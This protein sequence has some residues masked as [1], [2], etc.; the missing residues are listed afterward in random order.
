MGLKR[1][2]IEHCGSVGGRDTTRRIVKSSSKHLRRAESK[3]I[4]RMAKQGGI[5]AETD[6]KLD[7]S[8]MPF[9]R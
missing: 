5:D 9:Y 8:T 3:R 2:K 4:E 6:A 1:V 7:T